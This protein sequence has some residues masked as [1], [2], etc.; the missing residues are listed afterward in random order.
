M[1]KVYDFDLISAYLER[2]ITLD[3]SEYSPMATRKA[4][5]IHIAEQENKYNKKE[6]KDK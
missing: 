5:A 4:Y 3:I 6:E 1:S 2:K